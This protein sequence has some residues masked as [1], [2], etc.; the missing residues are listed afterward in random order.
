M[1]NVS[2]GNFIQFLSGMSLDVAAF[3]VRVFTSDFKL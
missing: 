3:K 1:A 2:V